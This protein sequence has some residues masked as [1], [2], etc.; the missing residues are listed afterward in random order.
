[1]QRIPALPLDTTDEAV[2]SLFNAI[3]QKMGGV[4][5]ILRTMAQ[6]PAAL[7]AYLGF[8]GAIG[9]GRFTAAQSELAALAAAGENSCDYCASAHSALGKMAGLDQPD[10]QQVIAGGN[11]DGGDGA[12]VT[13]TRQILNQ[14]GVL[15]DADVEAFYAAGFD[16]GHLVELIALTAL[17]IFTN[18]FNHI[19]ATEIDFPVVSTRAA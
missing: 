14:R 11:L 15:S 16:E 8:S 10:M 2:S 13:L 4:P 17:N 1:M 19:A 9:N 18:Y 12:I 7:E 5:N 6:S 3:R